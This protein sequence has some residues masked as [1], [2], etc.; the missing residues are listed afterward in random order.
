MTERVEANG[1]AN[2]TTRYT[3][4]PFGLLGTITDNNQHATRF[5]YD[6]LGRRTSLESPS[7]GTTTTT[8]TGFGEIRSETDANGVVHTYDRD[9]LGRVYLETVTSLTSPTSPAQTART[10]WDTAPHGIGKVS[11]T[12][13][14]DGIVSS[15]VYDERGRVSAKTKTVDGVAY[16]LGLKY[17]PAGRLETLTYPEVTTASG[18]QRLEVQY[19][20]KPNGDLERV[21]RAGTT[22]EYWRANARNVRGQL[23]NETFGDGVVMTRDYEP[24]RGLPFNVEILDGQTR[25]DAYMYNFDRSRLLSR[26]YRAGTDVEETF[27]YDALNRLEYWRGKQ[28]T[29]TDWSVQYR[30]N[31]IGNLTRRTLTNSTGGAGEDL[32]YLYSGIKA[33]PDAVTGSPWGSYSYDAKGNRVSGPD[34]SIS[35]TPFDLPSEIRSPSNALLARFAYD[36]DG[37][38]TRKQEPQAGDP[39]RLKSTIYVDGMFERRT[40]DGLDTF[41]HYVNAEDVVAQVQWAIA[42]PASGGTAAGITETV[43]YLHTDRLGGAHDHALGEW[44]LVGARP[45]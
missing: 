43:S 12:T 21:T 9:R 13:S 39:Q 8:Y 38:R 33:G 1:T 30:Y 20:Y 25:I 31:D 41:V 35:Y 18:P 24:T 42:T 2:I 28:G 45:A 16:S 32:E 7:S 27:E 15:Y 5:F 37:Q 23:R 17:D 26:R 10:E 29:A 36:A 14:L 19:G 34:G 11:Q 40:L 6:R 44:R 3:Y 4:R 22:H